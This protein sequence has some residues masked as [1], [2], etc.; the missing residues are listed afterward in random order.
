VYVGGGGGCHKKVIYDN[1]STVAAINKATSRSPELLA[2]VMD[3]FWLSVK[4]DFRLSA[5]YIPGLDNVLSDRIS[6]MR[7][8]AEA[9]EVGYLL[10]G[11]PNCIIESKGHMT[12]STFLYLQDLWEMEWRG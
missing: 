2:I 12:Y 8:V 10:S 7:H 3:L 9:R 5:S 11:D 4:F 1:K 6:R